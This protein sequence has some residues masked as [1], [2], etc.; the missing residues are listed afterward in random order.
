MEQPRML[1]RLAS[2]SD[3]L[4]AALPLSTRADLLEQFP[5]AQFP[6]TIQF[7]VVTSEFYSRRR[8][9]RNMAKDVKFQESL[10]QGLEKLQSFKSIYIT[11]YVVRR[12]LQGSPVERQDIVE[13][14]PETK[15]SELQRAAA[16][17]LAGGGRSDSS[18]AKPE[19]K[20]LKGQGLDKTRCSEMV[21]F[22]KWLWD[23]VRVVRTFL[24]HQQ[25]ICDSKKGTAAE[26]Y[27]KCCLS[28][29][30]ITLIAF[31]CYE[32]KHQNWPLLN[33]PS[34]RWWQSDVGGLRN[35]PWMPWMERWTVS[36]HSMRRWKYKFW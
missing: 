32:E 2:M 13:K 28:C 7:D 14:M 27:V 29:F 31:Q 15:I 17:R 35:K 30:S 11:C 1:S 10:L 19:T 6:V 36:A 26:C 8:Q 9:Q 18:P 20:E 22:Q 5:H 33:E 21:G 24:I 4:R 25:S 16:Q 12:T 23:V 34:R 3:P